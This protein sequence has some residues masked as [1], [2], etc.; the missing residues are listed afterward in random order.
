ML[1]NKCFPWTRNLLVSKKTMQRHF[2]PT[3]HPLSPIIFATATMVAF[4]L[5]RN[6]RFNFHCYT[7]HEAMPTQK[8]TQKWL[9]DLSR[10]LLQKITKGIHSCKPASLNRPIAWA[11]SYCLLPDTFWLWAPKNAFN[12]DSVNLQIHHHC[13]PL[14]RKYTP[15]VKAAKE[16]KP[17][18]AKVKGVNNPAWTTQ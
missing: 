6:Y 3:L 4:V 9:C 16:L 17:C 1:Q 13:L 12:I 10:L 7:Q 8:L 15:E 2:F 14:W 18:Q 11:T 5:F